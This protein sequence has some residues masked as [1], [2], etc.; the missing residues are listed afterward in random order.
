MHFHLFS[1]NRTLF[2]ILVSNAFWI[3]TFFLT[4]HTGWFTS[5]ALNQGLSL[6]LTATDQTPTVLHFYA[7][8]YLMQLEETNTTWWDFSVWPVVRPYQ[9]ACDS[10]NPI[11]SLMK[12][13][14]GAG[15]A[16]QSPCKTAASLPSNKHQQGC[17]LDATLQKLFL[18]TQSSSS[19][20]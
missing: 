16:C 18:W 6:T 3:L 5:T 13:G 20:T 1:K 12:D 4:F 9:R 15:P 17:G 19:V 14:H 10:Y 8:T 2:P 11:C 7:E